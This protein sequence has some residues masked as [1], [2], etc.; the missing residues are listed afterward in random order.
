M[1]TLAHI[2]TNDVYLGMELLSGMF[3][4]FFKFYICL[5]LLYCVH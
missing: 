1:Y 4:C 2:P 5:P 3:T